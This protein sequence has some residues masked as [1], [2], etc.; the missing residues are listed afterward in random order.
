MVTLNEDTNGLNVA[1]ATAIP[2]HPARGQLVAA[3]TATPMTNFTLTDVFGVLEQVAVTLDRLLQEAGSLDGCLWMG[4][5]EASGAVWEQSS[6]MN[7][8]RVRPR[9]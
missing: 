9:P 7:V 4:L 3:R 2:V 5:S 8:K 6:S 1:V